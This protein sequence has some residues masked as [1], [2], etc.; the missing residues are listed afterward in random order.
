MQSVQLSS[1][2]IE[3]LPLIPNSV[4]PKSDI[5]KKKTIFVN[6]IYRTISWMENTETQHERRKFPG[7]L[8][9]TLFITLIISYL[10]ETNDISR[11][12]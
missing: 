11:G 6:R 5:V 12:S 9:F 10:R 7:H 1:L 3:I 2:P 4:L 8:P